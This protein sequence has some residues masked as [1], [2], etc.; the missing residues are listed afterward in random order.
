M[1]NNANSKLWSNAINENGVAAAASSRSVLDPKHS[2]SS[3]SLKSGKQQQQ[4]EGSPLSVEEDAY[5]YSV[6]DNDWLPVQ[7][8][9][10]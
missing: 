10:H 1:G 8:H 9:C 4:L 6:Q 5:G 7:V 2:S 3:N